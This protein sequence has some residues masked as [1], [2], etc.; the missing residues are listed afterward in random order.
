MTVYDN[1]ALQR[2][3]LQ[4]KGLIAFA[5][6]QRSGQRVVIPHVEAPHALRGTGTASRL[7]AGIV[8]MARAEGFKITPTCS[9]AAVWFR[10]H[11]DAEDVLV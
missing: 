6:Y 7:M 11:K 5:N 4:E 8:A 9:Y 1:P 2:F 3:E 10:R